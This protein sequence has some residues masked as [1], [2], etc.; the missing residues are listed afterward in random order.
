LAYPLLAAFLFS[1]ASCKEDGFKY[2]QFSNPRS[3]GGVC[4]ITGYLC[5]QVSC[6]EK[7]TKGI[8]MGVGVVA[9]GVL[10]ITTGHA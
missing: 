6:V 2:P 7:I 8:L 5:R 9:V 4:Y 3:H 10:L 1:F